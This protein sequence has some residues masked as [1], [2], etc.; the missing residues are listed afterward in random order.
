MA[1]DLTKNSWQSLTRRNKICSDNTHPSNFLSFASLLLRLLPVPH[2][3]L[4]L[5]LLCLDVC[6][7]DRLKKGCAFLSK[8][9][10]GTHHTHYHFDGL[11]FTQWAMATWNRE[12]DALECCEGEMRPYLMRKIFV[13]PLQS[14]CC[15]FLLNHSL[16]LFVC[17]CFWEDDYYFYFFILGFSDFPFLPTW[18]CSF[19]SS[20]M[21][22]QCYLLL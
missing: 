20:C 14:S 5:L 15:N 2:V 8:T 6:L 3:L 19:F 10:T 22:A 21:H 13:F 18:G 7:S 9:T 12:W 4:L 16:C 1:I 11:L 17:C